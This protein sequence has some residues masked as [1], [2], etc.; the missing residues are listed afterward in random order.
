M[1]ANRN[2]ELLAILQLDAFGVLNHL[3]CEVCHS[4]G[5]VL[6]QEA[7]LYLAFCRFEATTRHVGLADCLDLLETKLVA[8]LIESMVDLIKQAQKLLAF[9]GLHN[10]VKGEDVDENDGHHALI[11]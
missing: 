9:V 3:Q 4:H 11:V 2:L 5:M 10:L 6:V 1:N 7:L 8:Q